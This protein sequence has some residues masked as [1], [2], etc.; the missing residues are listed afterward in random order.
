L[1]G[2]QG[3]DT[4]SPGGQQGGQIIESLQEEIDKLKAQLKAPSE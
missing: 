2:K 3:G 1:H 4:S